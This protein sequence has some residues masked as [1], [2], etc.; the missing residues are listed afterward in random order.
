VID[1]GLIRRTKSVCPTCLQE[2]PADVVERESGIYLMKECPEHGSF[3]QILSRRPS[4]FRTKTNVYFSL[5]KDS[6]KQKDFLVRLTERCNL[7]C[8]ICLA[9]PN[10]QPI[11]DYPIPKLEKFADS[12]SHRLKIDLMTAEPTMREDLE[13][14]IRSMRRR[15]HLVALHTNGIRIAERDYLKKLVDAGITEVHLQLDSFDDTDYRVIRGRPLKDIKEKALENLEA[16]D[17]K[18]SLIMTLLAGVNED[19]ISAILEYGMSHKHVK[20]IFFL[21]CRVLGDGK[22]LADSPY[23]MPDE[24]I[25]IVERQTEGKITHANVTRFQKIYFALLS[26]FKVRKCFYVQ[27]YLAVRKHIGGWE[28]IE[29][30]VDLITAEHAVDRYVEGQNRGLLARFKFLLSLFWS[31]LKRGGLVLILILAR[32]SRLFRFGFDLQKVPDRMVLLGFV[33]TCDPYNFDVEVAQ[34]CG[35]GEISMDQGEQDSGGLANIYRE[36]MFLKQNLKA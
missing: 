23:L 3:S 11:P 6:Y 4:D 9:S 17:V 15:G 31:I 27:H 34:N 29:K 20:E 32:L 16:L 1:A 13:D 30:W 12:K 35:K 25:D 36:R 21:G 33:T 22:N 28:G 14:I 8:P 10:K 26:I 18:T 5:M 19:Q 7:N 24:V 2:I